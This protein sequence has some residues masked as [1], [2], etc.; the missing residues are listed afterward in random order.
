M[1][2][3]FLVFLIDLL[4]LFLFIIFP[5]DLLYLFLNSLDVILI[6]VCLCKTFITFAWYI[7]IS[8]ANYFI[9]LVRESKFFW[10]IDNFYATSK[11]GWR[12]IISLIYSICFSFWCTK[13]YFSTTCSVLYISLFW[14][15]FIF[16]FISYTSGSVPS[17]FLHRCTF[18]GF[19]NSSESA[20]TFNFY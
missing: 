15:V 3:Y 12:F 18:K 2:Q 1:L 6:L 4:S 16:Y 10:R 14:R 8:P 17:R 5:A 19:Y 20:F 9:F 7:L 13:T 11:P